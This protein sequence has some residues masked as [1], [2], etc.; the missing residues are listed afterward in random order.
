[1]LIDSGFN[2]QD[3]QAI[4][5]GLSNLLADTYVLYLKTHNFH[6]NVSGPLFNT[7]HPMFEEQYTE[8]AVAVDSIANRIC[9]LGFPAPGTYSTFARLSSIKEGQEV[10][11]S[12]EMIEQLVEGHEA[13]VHTAR[14]LLPLVGR[15]SD[16]P[17][18]QLLCL[19]I[20]VHETT[21]QVLRSMGRSVG[22]F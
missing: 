17:T 12:H 14:Q 20:E 11:A 4:L 1:M 21:A 16:E 15:I 8:L 19:R 5:D 7:L 22:Q 6:W 9:E 2:Q 3:R 18:A 10:F 13:V